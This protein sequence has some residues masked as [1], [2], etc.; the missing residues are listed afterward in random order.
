MKLYDAPFSVRCLFMHAGIKLSQD[1]LDLWNGL[2]ADFRQQLLD[3]HLLENTIGLYDS[4]TESAN[5]ESVAWV[6]PSNPQM[7]L[8]YWKHWLT[9][10]RSSEDSELIKLSIKQI[11][12]IAC[13]T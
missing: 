2:S 1:P 7:R 12:A 11:R 5:M 13:L 10:G 8:T 3:E 4:I 9:V 6:R